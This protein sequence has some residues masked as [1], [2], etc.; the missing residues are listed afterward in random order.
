V[1]S[2]ALLT[3]QEL[4]DLLAEVCGNP[5][6][7]T[8]NFDQAFS[9]LIEH[10]GGFS[11]HPDDKGGATMW[12][13]TEQVARQNGYM[14]AMRDLTIDY[15]KVIYQKLY[16]DACRCGE[17]PEEVRFSVF[18]AAV[19]SGTGRAVKWLQR[20]VGVVDDGVIGS[21]TL[22]AA[23]VAIPAI[24]ATRINGL[25]LLFMTNQP[26]WGAFG[27]GWARRIASNLGA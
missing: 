22:A 18:D 27:K 19:N 6:E 14:G 23:R 7:Q 20:A 17:L 2:P 9:K 15:A 12:G 10:E 4:D 16:W 3:Q 5:T 11:N 24:T 1:S 8:M 21:F 13:V 26:N 25:R